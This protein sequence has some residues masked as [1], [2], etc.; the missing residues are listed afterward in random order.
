MGEERYGGGGE[1]MDGTDLRI[2]RDDEGLAG[3]GFPVL[4]PGL[5]G[6]SGARCT[7]VES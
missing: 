7:K 4:R 1:D 3:R 5:V 6:P 2:D